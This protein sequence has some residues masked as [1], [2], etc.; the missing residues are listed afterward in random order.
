MWKDS[1]SKVK[2]QFF[3]GTETSGQLHKYPFLITSN[4]AVSFKQWE[5]SD[6]FN[7]F[8]FVLRGFVLFACLLA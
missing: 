2:S 6:N 5:R 8:C 3:D 1:G 7:L 4:M